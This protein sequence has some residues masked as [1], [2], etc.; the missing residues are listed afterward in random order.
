MTYSSNLRRSA[1]DVCSCHGWKKKSTMRWKQWLCYVFPPALLW[2]SLFT[3]SKLLCALRTL[4]YPAR[5]P[6]WRWRCIPDFFF[7]DGWMDGIISCL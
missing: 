5:P 3:I 1:E 6:G 2:W 7:D 4:P